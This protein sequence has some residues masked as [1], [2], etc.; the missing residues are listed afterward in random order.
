MFGELI[1]GGLGILGAFSGQDA[2]EDANAANLQ[3][4]FDG[5]GLM[6]RFDVR[7]NQL[8]DNAYSLLEQSLAGIRQGYGQAMGAVDDYGDQQYRRI[9]QQ[10]QQ[11][12]AQVTQNLQRRGLGG[13]SV[14]DN[15][16]LGVGR[17][18]ADQQADLTAR[19][20]G[21]RGNLM[22]QQAQMEMGALGSLASFNFNR[23]GFES[24]QLGRRLDWMFNRQDVAGNSLTQG[25]TGAIGNSGLAGVAGSFLDDL[26]GVGGGEK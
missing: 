24:G 14:A 16:Q 21:L 20:A 15:A 9:N 2:A 5:L 10:G 25:I 1:S 23:A 11:A 7:S 4:Y 18:I 6:N 13:T 12:G 8:M 26:F 19:L 22:T 17:Q 3:R